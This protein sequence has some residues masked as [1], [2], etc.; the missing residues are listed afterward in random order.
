MSDTRR[1]SEIEARRMAS[2]RLGWRA[3]TVEESARRISAEIPNFVDEEDLHKFRRYLDEIVKAVQ[4]AF[5]KET[6][7]K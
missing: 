6:G 5:M 7:A 3:H 1:I 4:D 2:E